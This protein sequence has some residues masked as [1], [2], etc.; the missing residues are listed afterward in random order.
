MFIYSGPSTAPN[1]D[2]GPGH[3]RLTSASAWSAPHEEDSACQR[4]REVPLVG[5]AEK[6]LPFLV[7][8]AAGGSAD[9]RGV[10]HQTPAGIFGWPTLPLGIGLH[11][12]PVT[13]CAG[14]SI[15]DK[16]SIAT[17]RI[18]AGA[19]FDRMTDA[20]LRPAAKADFQKRRGD[21]PVMSAVPDSWKTP[22]GLPPFLVKTGGDELLSQVPA[23]SRKGASIPAA[24]DAAS[25]A[26]SLVVNSVRQC[27][28]VGG[29]PS[30]ACGA[31]HL[32]AGRA[33]PPRSDPQSAAATAVN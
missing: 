30:S 19:G 21:G 1:Y 20:G 7:D 9:V 3:A 8:V 15:G 29:T 12:W 4:A 14:M 25:P 32:D 28:L 24:A 23:L 31:F 6:P 5:M 33:V 13:A 22:R 16:A 17:A 26:V 2:L 27:P 18:L 11:T 10:S